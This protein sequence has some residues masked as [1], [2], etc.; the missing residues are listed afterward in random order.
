MACPCGFEGFGPHQCAVES[1]QRR[2]RHRQSSPEMLA[3]AGIAFETKNAGA[4]LIVT[5]NGRTVDFWPGTGLWHLRPH[6]G[7]KRRGVRELIA[8]LRRA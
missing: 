4:H 6:D 2:A 7:R 1:S 8:Y 3:A 5:H